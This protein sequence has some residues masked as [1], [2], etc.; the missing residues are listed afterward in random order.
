MCHSDYLPLG[1][2]NDPKAPWNIDDDLC[3]YCDEDIIREIFIEETYTSEQL[4]DGDI[5]EEEIKDYISEHS[6]CR[7]C[8]EEDICDD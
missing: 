4:M 1:A 7:Q 6:L 8:H 2:A 5:D 3:R